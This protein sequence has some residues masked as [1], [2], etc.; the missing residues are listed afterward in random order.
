[1]FSAVT[2]ISSASL[3]FPCLRRELLYMSLLWT[4]SC[5]FLPLG[6]VITLRNCLQVNFS[7]VASACGNVAFLTTIFVLQGYGL[8]RES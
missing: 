5:A 8:L 1:M 2:H 3:V 6:D 4:K 7:A